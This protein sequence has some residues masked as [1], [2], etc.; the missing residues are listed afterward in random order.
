MFLDEFWKRVYFGFK[1]HNNIA[2]MSLCTLVSAG[3]CYTVVQKNAPLFCSFSVTVPCRRLYTLAIVS[4]LALVKYL[5]FLTLSKCFVSYRIVCSIG[6]RN[7]WDSDTDNCEHH[8][9]FNVST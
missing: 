5:K 2:G 1:S 9:Y 8:L 6:S 3:F 4:F 7:I